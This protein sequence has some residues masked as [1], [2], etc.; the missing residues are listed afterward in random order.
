MT[1]AR[2]NGLYVSEHIALRWYGLGSACACAAERNYGI[3]SLTEGKQT[4]CYGTRLGVPASNL[5]LAGRVYTAPVV[6]SAQGHGLL[7]KNAGLLAR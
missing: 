7:P 4:H 1:P 5:A 3:G 2:R 6:G